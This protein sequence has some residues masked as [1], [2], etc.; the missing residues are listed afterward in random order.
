[1]GDALSARID[2]YVRELTE[3]PDRHV[4]SPGNQAAIEMFAER[5]AHFGFEVSRTPIDCIEWEYDDAAVTVGP[6]RFDLFVGPYSL[7]FDGRAVLTHA[8][9]V[10]DLESD[11]I[12]GT[13]VVLHGE[14][15][16][17][18]IMPK[19]FTFYNPESHRRIVRAIEKHAPAALIAA[20]GRDPEMVGSQ[21]PFPLFEDGDLDVPNAYM[22]DIEGERLIAHLGEDVALCIDSR[23]AAATAEHLVATR[24]GDGPGRIVVFA[25]IDSRK[26]SPGALDNA[27]GVATL[28]GLAELLADHAHGPTIEIVPLNGEDNYANPGEMLWVAANE[29]QMDDIILG[30]NI[31]DAGMVGEE[32][33]VS[34]YGCQPHFERI[35]AA[36]LGAYPGFAEGPT[37]FQSDHAIFGLYGRPAIA[38]ATA[39]IA[40]FMAKYAHS[41]RDTIELVDPGKLADAARFLRDVIKQVSTS[42]DP[43][44]ADPAAKG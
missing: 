14:I 39:D 20:T 6:D 44:A 10:G 43:S 42:A 37:W 41:E 15:A 31:D 29:G 36:A 3:Y 38:L 28:L 9:H 23:R 33:H 25:H 24:A 35:I 2:G 5:I 32:T 13:I 27:A 11:R 7:P 30:I 16:R 21:Y 1:M 40:G 17:A 4:G 26:G 34:S 12:R 8:T 19:N 22:T 18:Q